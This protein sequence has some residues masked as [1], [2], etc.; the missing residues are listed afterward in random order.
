MNGRFAPDFPRPPFPLASVSNGEFCPRPPTQRQM[1]VARLLQEEAETR[2]R[3]HGMTRAQF[4]RTAM[5]TATAFMVL[6][7][8]HGLDAWGDDA[9][10]PVQKIE[11][12]DPEAA[13]FLSDSYFIMDVQT[14]HV[15]LTLPFLQN[16][17]VMQSV[18]GL[19][20]RDRG[21]T[22]EA[23]LQLLGQL[24]F[25]KE[26]LID[27][28]TDVAVIS[29]IP[30]GSILPVDTMAQT[31]DLANQLAGSERMLSQAMIDPKEPPGS[32]TSIDSMER[33]VRE[34]GARTVKCYTGSGSWWLDAEDSGIPLIEEAQRLGVD[35]INVHKGLA[36]ILGPM[37]KEWVRSRDLP[38]VSAAYPDMKFVA[39][40]SGFELD[41][42]GIGDFVDNL[43]PIPRK[44]RKNV[45][46]EIGSTFALTSSNPEQAAHVLGQLLK[47]VGPK[48][49]LWG[50]DSIWWGS[51]QWQI[52]AFKRVQI[53]ASMRE[54]FGYPPLTEKVKRRIFGLNAARLY[55][56][57]PKQTRCAIPAEAVAAVLG[58]PYGPLPGRS[59]VV[60]GPRTR[61]EFLTL[62]RRERGL[63]A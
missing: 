8:V 33:Q 7:R 21:P 44:K 25:V 19:R 16:P 27:S 62:L 6:N 60:Y 57:K 53:P 56:V 39:Y 30:G 10:F 63:V 51:P 50:T 59:N 32:Q 5:G 11:C 1:Q 48:R 47:L 46:A 38:V 42:T 18:C 24:N 2:A 34:L 43:A 22:C 23:S 35:V 15:D 40:H 36:D 20:F 9:V 14:H 49:I 3:R 52:E 55:K 45:Y 4:L 54:E 61:R 26:M 17:V 41:G 37:A 12:D 31:R 28:E 58:G 29:G 13:A